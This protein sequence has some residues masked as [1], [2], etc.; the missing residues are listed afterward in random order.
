MKTDLRVRYTQSVIR[1][2]FWMILKEKPLGKITVKEVCDKAGV[3]RGTFYKHYLDCFD[4]MEQIEMT[5][6]SRFE[7][8]LNSM[9]S[10]GEL[11]MLTSLLQK[12]K[13]N[14]DFFEI[15]YTQGRSDDFYNR[16]ARRC[17][18]H[19]ENTMADLPFNE[20]NRSYL[21]AF[22]IGGASSVISTWIRNGMQDT[23]EQ[24]AGQIIR[25]G[26]IA[27]NGAAK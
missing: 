11:V 24:I 17:Y 21:F 18:Q 6:L 9:P 12:L 4:L 23:P 14:A 5:A 1:E 22:L 25:L 8:L 27:V 13:E 10:H 16:L 26:T 3:N 19:L 7:D 15:L 20:R 2:A